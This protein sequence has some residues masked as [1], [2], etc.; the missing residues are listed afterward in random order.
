MFKAWIY[1]LSQIISCQRLRG[2]LI[3]YFSCSLP[4]RPEDDVLHK[5]RLYGVCCVDNV[6]A[7]LHCKYAGSSRT[8]FRSSWT[9]STA[10]WKAVWKVS[11]TGSLSD[12][13]DFCHFWVT[14]DFSWCLYPEC[15]R[16]NVWY[17]VWGK[18]LSRSHCALQTWASPTHQTMRHQHFC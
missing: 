9:C 13:T 1:I 8:C 6:S 15:A 16:W 2:G 10:A 7:R 17:E 11:Q 14:N 4:Q 5:R 3:H 12:W 18:H